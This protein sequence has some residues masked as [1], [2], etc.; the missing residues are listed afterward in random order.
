VTLFSLATGLLALVSTTAFAQ[1]TLPST[2]GHAAGHSDVTIDATRPSPRGPINAGIANP[3]IT[4]GINH[5]A[6]AGFSDE[7]P[8]GSPSM[9]PKA[10]MG[11]NSP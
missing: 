5:K 8:T 7:R 2:Q 3:G 10:T 1:S 11:P 4:T 9:P 6:S